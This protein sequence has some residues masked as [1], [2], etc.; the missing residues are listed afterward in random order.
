MMNPK[1]ISSGLHQYIDRETASV[2]SEQLYGD[3]VVNYLYS[4]V[5]EK[6]PLLFQTLTSSSISYLVGRWNYDA[7][8]GPA[9][10]G[11][12]SFC[13]KLGI[14]LS[15]CVDDPARLDSPRKVFERKIRYWER[16]PMEADPSTLVS[17]ADSKLLVG[18]LQTSS[19]LFLKGKFF[20]VYELLG[21]EKASWHRTFQNG[22]FAVF[23]LTPDDYHYNHAPVTGVVVD[24]YEID[25]TY[26]SCNPGPVISVVTP[27][28]KN[29]R[30]VTVIDTDVPGGTRAGLVAMIEIVALMIGAIEQRYSER[31][32]DDPQRM[33]KGLFVKKGQPKSLYRPGSSTDVLLLQRGRVV[34][35][36]D[37]RMN[38]L[39]RDAVSRYSLG[40]GRPAVE[41]AVKV[42]STIGRALP[43]EQPRELS[44]Q[45]TSRRTCD[46]DFHSE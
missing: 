26:H 19:Q 4:A 43:H 24:H 3:R 42:R 27:Y 16:R 7:P 33:E 46:D 28:S 25:G 38:Q 21:H 9:F 31:F 1:S 12:S 15:E 17:P 8:F 45:G 39:R 13:R 34:F 30:V 36:Q 23:R 35:C 6:A 20:D 2:R 29:K 14:D 22:D 40:F 32:Y 44:L 5:R 41:T 11:V 37:L 18:S 10:S